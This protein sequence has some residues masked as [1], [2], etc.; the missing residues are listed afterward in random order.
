M[1]EVIPHT[2]FSL[3]GVVEKHIISTHTLFIAWFL[4]KN[5]W[6]IS[7][8]QPIHNDKVFLPHSLSYDVCEEA[9]V[10]KTVNYNDMMLQ[11]TT[12]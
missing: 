8:W 10:W 6:S 1:V 7:P 3:N 12:F 11:N 2:Q 4:L 9:A 5:T